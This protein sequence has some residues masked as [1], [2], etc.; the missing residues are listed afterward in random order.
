MRD[1]NKNNVVMIADDDLFVRKVIKVA[2]ENLAEF[3][4]VTDGAQVVEICKKS[5]PDLIFLDIHLPNLSG[6]ELLPQLMHADANAHVI[7]LSADSSEENVRNTMRYGSRG[8]MT[9]PFN[10]QRVLDYFT[11]CPTIKFA[12][13]R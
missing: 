5:K 1:A 12:D 2:L 4:E 6:L 7:M 3:I 11:R 10:K 9:K 8:F 13:E